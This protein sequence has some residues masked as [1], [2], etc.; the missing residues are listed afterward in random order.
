ME[1]GTIPA[2]LLREAFAERKVFPCLFGSAL[3][4]QG[5]RELMDAVTVFHIEKPYPEQCGARVYKITQDDDGTRLTHVR[6]TGGKM[7]ARQ[8]LSEED[9]VDQIRRYS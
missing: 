7:T 8:K 6:I 2:D 4:G 5:V 9:K 1:T 3:K